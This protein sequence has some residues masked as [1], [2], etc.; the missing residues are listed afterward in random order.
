MWLFYFNMVKTVS[1]IGCGWLGLPLG[2]KL[3]DKGFELHGTTTSKNKLKL[4]RDQN[5]LPYLLNLN[6]DHQPNST[7]STLF[8]SDVIVLTIPP[9]VRKYGEEYAKTQMA[10]L[11]KHRIKGHVIYTSSTSVYP[12]EN[13]A[14]FENDDLGNNHPIAA[15]EKQLITHFGRRLTILR[16]GG[17]F[18]NDR[19]PMKYFKDKTVEN[20]DFPVNYLHQFD[21]VNSILKV[22]EKN[23]WGKIYNIVAPKHPK[24][25]AVLTHN[26]K[27]IGWQLPKYS[28][29]NQGNFKLINGEKFIREAA[30]EYEYPD[31]ITF[32]YLKIQT[33]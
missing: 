20:G 3:V 6:E 26:A 33:P 31:P 17:L 22:I 24:K 14:C 5:I 18:G 27:E 10:Q 12:T 23:L 8:D 11:L 9:K 32:D 28:N 2:K 21:A 29:K 13:K 19:F 7:F 30:F 16:L 4:L 25:R 15:I 1:I